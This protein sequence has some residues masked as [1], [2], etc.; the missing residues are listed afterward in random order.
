M[1]AIV[2]LAVIILNSSVL[3]AQAGFLAERV[4]IETELTQDDEASDVRMSFEE[5]VNKKG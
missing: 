4:R 1:R 3:L 2:T 5:I